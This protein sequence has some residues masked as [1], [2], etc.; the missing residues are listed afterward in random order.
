MARPK[1]LASLSLDALL[2][3]RDDLGAVLSRRA[4]DMQQQIQRLTGTSAGRSGTAVG[5][6]RRGRR[7]GGPLK[8]RKIAPKYRGPG[9]ETWAGRGARP[10]WLVAALKKGKKLG[11]FLIAK[12]A[13]RPRAKAPKRRKAKR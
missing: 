11:D 8:G 1:S 4:R 2:K 9:G 7:R 3:L 10:R 5:N 12:G 13:A 6:G